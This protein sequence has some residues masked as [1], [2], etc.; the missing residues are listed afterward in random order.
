M[1]QPYHRKDGSVVAFFIFTNMTNK[2]SIVSAITIIIGFIFIFSGFSKALDFSY[3]VNIIQSYGINYGN[4]IGLLIVMTELMLGLFLVFNCAIRFTS[5]ICILVVILFTL[6]YTFGYFSL[7]VTDCGCFGKSPILNSSYSFFII[8]NSLI[9]LGLI[10][11]AVNNKH[12]IIDIPLYAYIT[13]IILVSLATFMCGKFFTKEA[14]D[15]G[16]DFKKIALSDLVLG[17]YIETSK[18]STY[19]VSILSYDCPH[20]LNSIGNLKQFNEAKYV[21]NVICLFRE[22][23][24]KKKIFNEFFNPNFKII[25]LS[26]DVFYKITNEYPITYFVKNDTVV[27]AIKGEIPSGFFF[28]KS[29]L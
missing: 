23:N 26:E 25:D 20:C 5:F 19:M 2:K 14:H 27:N 3:F 16:H 10:W 1:L 22:D 12:N 29:R 7:D 13:S 18:D 17:H 21:D 11:I 4:F 24:S 15:K 6:V 9:L 8:R 28:I